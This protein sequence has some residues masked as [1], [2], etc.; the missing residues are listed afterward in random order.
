M[1]YQFLSI[2]FKIP[3]AVGSLNAFI[4]DEGLEKI[5]MGSN[6]WFDQPYSI[7]LESGASCNLE[8]AKELQ[9]LDP[10]KRI[11]ETVR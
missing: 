3:P 11:C 8:L 5:G 4:H 7:K 2:D 10:A 1:Q 6:F 9:I